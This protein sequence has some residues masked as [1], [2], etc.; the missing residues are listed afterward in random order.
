[1]VFNF[2][3][4]E[5]NRNVRSDEASQWNSRYDVWS[6]CCRKP[7]PYRLQHSL[8]T[9][10]GSV[11]ARLAHI[12]LRN[13][14]MPAAFIRLPYGF[15]LWVAKAKAKLKMVYPLFQTL[16]PPSERVTRGIHE[17]RRGVFILSNNANTTI[18]WTN[19]CVKNRLWEERLTKSI[20][21]LIL[22]HYHFSFL[23]FRP[24]F[25]TFSLHNFPQIR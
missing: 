7:L 24:L 1:M 4:I 13:D 21:W 8:A 17:E 9:N 12:A 18:F 10:M 20:H 22:I 14:I 6:D 23:Y 25:P 19:G 16:I 2:N 15:H 3:L 5:F 11:A